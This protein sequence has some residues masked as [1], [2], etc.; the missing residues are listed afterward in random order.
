M[1][2]VLLISPH[3][4]PDSSAASHRVRLLAPHLP[5]FGWN[6]TVLTVQEEALC[7][8]ADPDLLSLVPRTLR[9][10]RAP[11]IAAATARRLGF[12]DLGLR[13]LGGLWSCVT[14]L[15]LKEDFDVLF[16]TIYPTYPALLGPALKARFGVP[17]VLDYQ[18][19]WVSEWGRSVGGGARGAVDIRSA[20]SRL[21][22]LFL[23]PMAV[24]DANGLTAVSLATLQLVQARVPEA[25]RLPVL[26][27]PIGGEE[28][29]FQ[30]VPALPV[31]DFEEG[32]FHFVYVGTVLPRGLE[33]VRALF[34]AISAIREEEP[35]LFA[36]LRWHFIG[37]SNQRHDNVQ[38]RVR[39]LAEQFGIAH[40]VSEAPPRVA[41]TRAL[42]ALREA[43]A[44]LLLGSD[45]PH[46]TA[47]KLYPALLAKRPLLAVFHERSTVVRILRQAADAPTL[48]LV[49]F[50]DKQRV[51]ER[52]GPIQDALRALVNVGNVSVAHQ[53]SRL[54]EFS[55]RSLAGRLA[56]FFERVV[57][58][59]IGV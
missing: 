32:L 42:R 51:G 26:E 35:A 7:G 54:E 53:A 50:D 15:L 22:S 31:R 39:P 38:P 10:V 49:T 55:A 28:R 20:L 46:Y 33:T 57:E 48:R 56:L 45:E 27:L 23:E 9:V 30:N 13:A 19:P 11:A 58:A 18:D 3:F 17:F 25:R 44:I 6:P 5:T 2:R 24:R 29:D 52:V 36:R 47:S 1:R 8:Q 14:T 12:G 40:V 43:S 34:T 21:V 37:T 4:P 59:R 41:Y 16:I